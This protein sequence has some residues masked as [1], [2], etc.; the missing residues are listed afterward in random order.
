MKKLGFVSVCLFTMLYACTKATTY[1]GRGT[2]YATVN[3]VVDTFSAN[4]VALKDST[5]TSF[6]LSVVG[7]KADLGDSANGG[8]ESAELGF[9]ITSPQ[10]ITAGAYVTDTTKRNLLTMLYLPANKIVY[11]SLLPGAANQPSVTITSITSTK[12][13]GT[14]SGFAFYADST[15]PTK[16][17]IANANF[18]ASFP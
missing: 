18:T 12:V 4:V 11:D 7:F 3:G 17:T 10:H 2:I 13:I 5:D 8:F 9:Q 14:F 16:A 15:N 6:T 1:G